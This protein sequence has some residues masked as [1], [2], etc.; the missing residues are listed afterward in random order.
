MA[1]LYC[2]V[3]RRRLI[4]SSS[5]P[6]EFVHEQFP[7]GR[8]RRLLYSLGIRSADAVVVQSEEQLALARRAFP[9]ICVGSF[10]FQASRRGLRSR[11][12][13]PPQARSSGLVASLITRSHV[14]TSSSHACPPESRFSH[15]SRSTPPNVTHHRAFRGARRPAHLTRTCNCW[16]RLSHVEA[17]AAQLSPS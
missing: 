15:G 5:A 7:D 9:R 3:R 4:F 8:A 16:N 12:S 6:Y 2:Y 11:P 14:G 10:G 13:F 1:A 17:L